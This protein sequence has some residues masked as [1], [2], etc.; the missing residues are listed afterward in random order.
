MILG[1][2]GEKSSQTPR[3]HRG[4]RLA[5]RGH[6]AGI[7][8]TSSPSSAGPPGGEF[9]EVM[10]LDELIVEFAPTDC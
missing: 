10:T 4:G 9:A 8:S 5:T 1:A 7:W 3:G 2:D 6:P